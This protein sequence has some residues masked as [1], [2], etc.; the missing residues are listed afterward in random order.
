MENFVEKVLLL[1]D[2]QN[3]YRVSREI[4]GPLARVDFLELLKNVKSSGFPSVPR[5]VTAIAYVAANGVKEGTNRTKEGLKRN[6]KLVQT[7]QKFGYQVVLYDVNP[8]GGGCGLNIAVQAMTNIDKYS[9]F[10]LSTGNED[11]LPLLNSLQQAGKRVSYYTFK[12]EVTQ[13][14]CDCVED[15]KYLDEVSSFREKP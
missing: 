7:L 13:A 11:F 10:V 4:A 14:L 8:V 2:C 5:E 1:V 9:T 15:I 6:E 3:L 12:Q